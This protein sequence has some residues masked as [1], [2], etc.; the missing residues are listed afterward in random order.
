MIANYG[1]Y[2]HHELDNTLLLLFSEHKANKIE[3]LGEV[4]VLCFGDELVAYRIK[5]FI[6]YAKIKY[7]GIIYLPNNI[8][9]DIINSVLEKYQLEK[10]S[11]KKE[12]GYVTKKNLDQ[13][14]VYVKE[15][16]FL[17]DQTV[18]K[19]KY[20]SYYDLYIDDDDDQRLFVIDENIQEGLD[21]FKTEEK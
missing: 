16:V 9:I 7:S 12:S 5:N 6:R 18:S 8:L 15:G 19:G 4:E 10:L 2:N 11:Y 13:L 20:C 3:D 1:V 14:M 17:R 21:F